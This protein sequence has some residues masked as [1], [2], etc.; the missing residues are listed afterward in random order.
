MK[1]YDLDLHMIRFL[2]KLVRRELNSK[3]LK[4][5]TSAKYLTK[6]YDTENVLKS[7]LGK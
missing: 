6:M 7:G 3:K 5:S 2:L 1:V 4:S